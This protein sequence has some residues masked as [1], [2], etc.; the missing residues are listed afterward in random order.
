V[1]VVTP[2]FAQIHRMI[3]KAITQSEA[4]ADADAPTEDPSPSR[5][6]RQNPGAVGDGNDPREANS[7]DDLAETC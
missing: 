7:T 2:D 4:I 3:K 6:P 1:N 5:D